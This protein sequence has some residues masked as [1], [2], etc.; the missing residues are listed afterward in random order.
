[1][2]LSCADIIIFFSFF[3]GQY[4]YSSYKHQ[5]KY[6]TGPPSQAKQTSGSLINSDGVKIIIISLTFATKH[7]LGPRYL[8]NMKLSSLV[9]GSTLMDALH[10]G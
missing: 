1:M 2:H 4:T 9:A 7:Q 5:C 8:F 10:S 6:I 3:I